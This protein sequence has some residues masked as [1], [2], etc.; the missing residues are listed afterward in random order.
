LV[1]STLRRLVVLAVLF[2]AVLLTVYAAWLVAAFDIS[3]ETL[4]ARARSVEANIV[5][6]SIAGAD[7]RSFDAALEIPLSLSPERIPA[8]V[9][10]AFIT[11]EDQQFRWHPGVNPLALG[12]A[13]KG[14]AL[15]LMGRP[16]P[17]TGGS[18]I[19]M[20]LVKN[21]LLNQR[22]TLDRKFR[23]IVLAVIVDAVLSKDEI[24]AM[25]LEHGVLR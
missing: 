21:L 8:F 18:T 16:A 10:E 13:A 17:V 15:R 22:Q 1:V 12:R 14:Y 3:A 11:Q 6:S 24:L 25:Y 23:E 20:Q 7:G 5:P 19:T 2:P 9:A 4:R